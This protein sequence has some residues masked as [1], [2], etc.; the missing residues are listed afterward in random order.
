M[1]GFTGTPIFEDNASYEQIDGNVASLKT[2]RDIFHQELHAYTITN[3]IDDRNVLSFHIDY[4]GRDDSKDKTNDDAGQDTGKNQSRRPPAA[5]AVVRSILQKHDSATNHRRFNALLATASINDAID[6][7]RHFKQL[8]AE[9]QTAEPDFQPLNIACVFSPPA[10][11]NKDVQQLQEYLQQEKQ[12]NKQ[13]PEQKQRALKAIIADYNRQYGTNHSINEFD[14]YY[15]DVQQRIKHHRHPNAD[16]PQR[17]KIDL[18]I[19]VD[20]LLTG[21]DSQYLNTLYVDKN[22]QHH[23]LIQAFSRTNRVLNDS[24][25]WGNILDFRYQE[26]QVD[27]AIQLFSGAD[28]N[29]QQARQI[30]LVD[31]APVVIEKY[32]KAVASLD[33]FMTSQGLGCQPSEVPNLK[34][35]AAKVE[36]IRRFKEVQRLNTQLQQYTDLDEHNRQTIEQQLPADTLRGFR[37]AYIDT[38]KTLRQRKPGKANPEIDQLDFELVL[39]ASSLIDYDYIMQ[40]LAKSTQPGQRQPMTRQQLVDLISSDANL[41]DEREDLIAYINSLQAGKAL[42]ETDIRDGYQE[43]KAARA[44]AELQDIASRHGLAPCRV[45]DL[46]RWHPEADDFRRRA[47]YRFN[48]TAAAGLEGALQRRTATDGR[49]GPVAAEARRRPRDFRTERL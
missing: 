25:P 28:S 24:K 45:A 23:G 12:D 48:G 5:E 9:K 13:D 32:R 35:D 17:L 22:L 38:A 6:Y 44:A 27:A 31:K 34:G 46:C 8:Q 29:Q 33:D 21:F 10:D 30:W 1:F 16:H 42:E 7:Y 15:Q 43:F 20:M 49:P 41:M 40:L 47:A 2:T 11:G 18:T 36:F 14:L 4:F 26:S 19:V 39:F 3:A 37:A